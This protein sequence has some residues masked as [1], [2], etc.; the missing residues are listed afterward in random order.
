MNRHRPARL[1]GQPS[2]WDFTKTNVSLIAAAYAVVI[3]IIL[4]AR[5]RYNAQLEQFLNNT[6]VAETVNFQPKPDRFDIY[7]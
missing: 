2:K 3:C 4:T 7:T 6:Q 1:F 5:Q